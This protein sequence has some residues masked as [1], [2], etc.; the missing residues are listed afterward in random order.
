MHLPSFMRECTNCSCHCTMCF[1]M[2]PHA[3]KFSNEHGVKRAAL[4][5]TSFH[6]HLGINY[7]F[8]QFNRPWQHLYPLRS[9]FP[10]THRWQ[11]S[12]PDHQRR[13]CVQ[14][15]FVVPNAVSSRLSVNTKTVC[16]NATMPHENI[17]RLPS[18]CRHPRRCRLQAA[19]PAQ[20][21]WQS[22]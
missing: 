6:D 19:A 4:A 14:Q 10:R 18:C 15:F 13:H 1:D 12:H 2:C 16:V 17:F 20:V 11:G 8:Q 22:T 9:G 3:H 7:C 5:A 21:D